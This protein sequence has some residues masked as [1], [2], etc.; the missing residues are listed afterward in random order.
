MHVFIIFTMQ[1]MKLFCEFVA[2]QLMQFVYAGDAAKAIVDVQKGKVGKRVNLDLFMP[3]VWARYL[4]MINH[5]RLNWQKP[6]LKKLVCDH[7][8][9]LSLNDTLMIEMLVDRLQTKKK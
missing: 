4:N 3:E 8:D 5:Y 1:V 6:E 9:L 7:P 2:T